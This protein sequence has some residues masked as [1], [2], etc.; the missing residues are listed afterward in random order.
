[1]KHYWPNTLFE[2]CVDRAEGEGWYEIKCKLGL[3]AVTGPS[4]E[5]VEDHAMHYWIQYWTDGEYA[6]LIT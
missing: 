2:Q 5:S 4:K 3:W 6:K 1:M